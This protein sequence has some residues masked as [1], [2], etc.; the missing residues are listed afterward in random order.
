MTARKSVVFK[1]TMDVFAK[2]T[3]AKD[4][5]RSFVWDFGQVNIFSNSSSVTLSWSVCPW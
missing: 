4:D 2:T 3:E 1:I 5:L